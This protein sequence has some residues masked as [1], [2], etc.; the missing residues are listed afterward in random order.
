M[1]SN[2]IFP[3]RK[4]LRRKSLRRKSQPGASLCWCYAIGLLL[5]AVVPAF[6][7]TANAN[8]SC[9]GDGQ[10]VCKKWEQLRGCDRGYHRTKPIGGICTRDNKLIP[11]KLEEK[12]L[13][14]YEPSQTTCGGL[15]QRVCKKNEQLMGCDPGF[16]RTQ[17]IGGN[18]TADNKLVPDAV[19]RTYGAFSPSKSFQRA[20]VRRK[21]TEHAQLFRQYGDLMLQGKAFVEKL[22]ELKPNLAENEN[23]R[24]LS[25]ADFRD[26][27]GPELLRSACEWKFCTVTITVGVD[28]AN[29]V[30]G[31]V[32]G[33]VAFGNVWESESG[34]FDTDWLDQNKDI[35]T[36]GL[37]TAN[38]S[39]GFSLGADGSIVLGFWIP[40][41]NKMKGF[42]HGVVAGGAV[43]E[44]GVN[45]AA[46]WIINPAIT[47][48]EWSLFD[49][50][51]WFQE[52]DRDTFGGFSVGYQGGVSLEM[53]YD[54]G[55]TW[56]WGE[57]V[58]FA[59]RSKTGKCLDVH[60]PDVQRNGGRVQ[61]WDCHG[62]ANQNW[63]QRDG[64]L[65]SSTGMCLDAPGAAANGGPIQI[66]TCNGSPGQ[67]WT[68]TEET[69][70]NANGL[71][72]DV[73]RSS[74]MN[75][76]GKVLVWSCHGGNN[77][78]WLKR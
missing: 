73:A 63:Q 1:R 54:W 39:V 26:A 68:R 25:A 58:M 78:K 19:E 21:K 59:L 52:E 8:G 64:A 67:Q 40:E 7:Q 71:C 20:F 74:L 47:D 76:G 17:P 43:R 24:N 6:V 50:S 53:E 49:W 36:T 77:Q 65:I 12:L 75:N 5:V 22:W 61:V 31:N 72:L 60:G 27:G 30:G 14:S 51:T 10:R 57:P 29:V 23:I 70:V 2:Q 11:N 28:V 48:E 45:A 13:D 56:N 9:G 66:S 55:Y 34:K 35:D 37:L 38:G 46:W 69:Y 16:H 44:V 41:F 33:G 62:G 4:S 18:C 3:G 32:S 42:A 15:N